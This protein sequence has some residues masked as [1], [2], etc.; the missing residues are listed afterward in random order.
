MYFKSVVVAFSAL[1]VAVLGCG[2]SVNVE[3]VAPASGV[4]TFKGKAL[5]GYKVTFNPGENRRAATAITDANGKFKLG[6][7]KEGDGAAVGKHRVAISFISEQVTGEAGKEV[8]KTLT[9]KQK[10]SKDYENASTSG[11]EIEIP[12]AGN[13]Q[14][15]ITLTK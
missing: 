11:I 7:N 12:S 4:L 14:I 13:N 1:S 5:D 10:I 15:E 6:T 8:F 9:P 2:P 3:R